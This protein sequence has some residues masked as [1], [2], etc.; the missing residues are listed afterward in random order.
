MSNTSVLPQEGD[1]SEKE[2]LKIYLSTPTKQREQ[3]FSDTAHAAEV[4]GLSRRTIQFWIESGAVK[5]IAIGRRYEI[6][7][8]TLTGYLQSRMEGKNES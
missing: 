6:Y 2:L 1:L 4:T 8:P 3:I 7:L 5:A